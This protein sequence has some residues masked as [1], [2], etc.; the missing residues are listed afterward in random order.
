MIN[1]QTYINNHVKDICEVLASEGVNINIDAVFASLETGTFDIK[2]FSAHVDNVLQEALYKSSYSISR[3]APEEF[4]NTIAE[5]IKDIDNT[6]TVKRVSDF[7]PKEDNKIVSL[8]SGNRMQDYDTVLLTSSQGTTYRL[9]FTLKRGWYSTENIHIDKVETHLSLQYEAKQLCEIIKKIL[10]PIIEY[11][12]NLG[13]NTD[14]FMREEVMKLLPFNSHNWL[15]N[16]ELSIVE[17]WEYCINQGNWMFTR[18]SVQQI[19][20]YIIDNISQYFENS[21]EYDAWNKELR[22]VITKLKEL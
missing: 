9:Y 2:D 20:K 4:G 5:V 12:H 3:L 22:K 18:D 15:S 1:E 17:N 19:V 21:Q 13:V 7:L 16:K 8:Q 14:D 11:K 6:F 10:K